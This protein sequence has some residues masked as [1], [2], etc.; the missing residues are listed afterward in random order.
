MQEME[1]YK[2]EFRLEILVH[3]CWQRVMHPSVQAGYCLEKRSILRG[4]LENLKQD[5]PSEGCL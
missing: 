4:E 5:L 2:V 1:N 3:P